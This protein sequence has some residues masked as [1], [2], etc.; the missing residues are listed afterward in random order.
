MFIV[1][2]VSVASPYK[3]IKSQ[4]LFVKPSSSYGIFFEDEPEPLTSN[5]ISFV[6]SIKK[7]PIH[8]SCKLR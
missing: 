3:L 5:C 6:L 8:L 4:S 2:Q 7:Y 1:I